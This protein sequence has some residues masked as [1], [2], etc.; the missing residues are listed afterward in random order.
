V[1]FPAQLS[2]G[3]AWWTL[4][5][6]WESTVVFFTAFFQ[7]VAS[8]VVFSFGS[9]FRQTVFR[10]YLLMVS[11]ASIFVVISLAILLPHSSFT[12]LWHVASE[13]FNG[14]NTTSPVWITYQQQGGDPSAAMSFS[15]R[16]QFWFLLI[17]NIVVVALWQAVVVEGP[18][19]KIV[20]INFPSMQKLLL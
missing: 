3:Q 15:F 20:R 7:F 16:L 4:G 10:N 18:V 13:E 2:E 8:S 11:W 14:P 19:A 5:D 17:G 9:Q 1:K 12:H 6:N